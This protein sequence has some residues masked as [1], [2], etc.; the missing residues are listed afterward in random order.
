MIPS[1]S[2]GGAVKAVADA[3]KAMGVTR[4]APRKTA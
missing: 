4:I 3:L 1:G 2:I